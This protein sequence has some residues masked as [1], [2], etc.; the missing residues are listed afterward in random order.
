MSGKFAPVE[1]SLEQWKRD[2]QFVAAYDALGDE[3]AVA[4]ALIKARSDADMTQE[5]V[6]RAMGTTQAVIA[7][8]EG[9]RSNPRRGPWNGLP[10]RRGL[11]CA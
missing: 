3:F 4:S 1:E 10:R 2:P 9:G 11:S 8:L 6:A 5:E 7:R